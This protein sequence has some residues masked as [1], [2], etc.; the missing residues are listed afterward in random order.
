MRK[1]VVAGF[2]ALALAVTGACAGDDADADANIAADTNNEDEGG[3]AEEY[4]DFS[5]ELD[6]RG[7]TPSDEDLDRIVEVAPEEIKEDV[8]VLAD[9]IK[10]GDQDSEAAT[11]AVERLE[12]W[13]DE[14]CPQ[15]EGDAANEDAGA[16]GDGEGGDGS[17]GP[18]SGEPGESG[19]DDDSGDGSQGSGGESGGEDGAEAEVE[20]EVGSEDD[21]TSTTH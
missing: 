4:C 2:A 7:E 8:E 13:E 3:S 11:S 1:I 18:S 6:S 16:G 20:A 14:N 5:A 17:E 19:G 9:A 12:E 15:D 21:D 10:E